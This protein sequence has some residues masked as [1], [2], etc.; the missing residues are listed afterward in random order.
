MTQSASAQPFSSLEPLERISIAALL[1]YTQR[2]G[3][4][5]EEGLNGI[6]GGEGETAKELAPLSAASADACWTALDC[7]LYP[8]GRIA[9]TSSATTSSSS[10]SPGTTIPTTKTTTVSIPFTDVKQLLESINST[11]LSD[12]KRNLIINI[13]GL[14]PSSVPATGLKSEIG[15]NAPSFNSVSQLADFLASTAEEVRVGTS[16]NQAAAQTSIVCVR[17]K[18]VGVGAAAEEEVTVAWVAPMARSSTQNCQSTIAAGISSSSSSASVDSPS[19]AVLA[20]AAFDGIRMVLFSTPPPPPRQKRNP[21]GLADEQPTSQPMSALDFMDQSDEFRDSPLK[22]SR[23]IKKRQFAPSGGNV[24]IVTPTASS[25]IAAADPKKEATAVSASA[26]NDDEEEK[27]RDGANRLQTEQELEFARRREEKKAKERFQ[28]LRTL[29]GLAEQRR[30][31]IDETHRQRKLIK[32]I[33][34]LKEQLAPT[35]QQLSNL[36]RDLSLN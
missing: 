31:H 34:E 35:T 25:G 27:K 4:I 1:R 3:G 19:L 21:S 22:L 13:A 5:H 10:S 24:I 7:V 23:L 2:G 9:T 6:S 8:Q 33:T 18:S 11:S 16:I 17:L 14:N 20:Y 28:L 29:Q 26:V 12:G 32:S 15:M 30:R 36:E